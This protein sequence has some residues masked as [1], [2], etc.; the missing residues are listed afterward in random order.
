MFLL[1]WHAWGQSHL[2]TVGFCKCLQ[3]SILRPRPCRWGSFSYC[4]A[5][6]KNMALHP[7]HTP[8]PPRLHTKVLDESFRAPRGGGKGC[9]CCGVNVCRGSYRV[10]NQIPKKCGSKTSWI[11]PLLPVQ[12]ELED[13]KAQ[14]SCVWLQV[15][16]SH[17]E[18][19]RQNALQLKE[20]L[21][22]FISLMG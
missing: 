1:Q 10:I 18:F 11:L 22:C 9:W 15:A 14:W 13:L 4:P 16:G 20:A 5:V 19:T 3:T 12:W 17:E 2:F 21:T 8:P 7:P 6:L